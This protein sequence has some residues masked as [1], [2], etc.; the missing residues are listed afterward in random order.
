LLELESDPYSIFI[1]AMNAPQTREKYTTRLE[2]FFDFIDLP[3]SNNTTT[4]IEER[5]KYFVEKAKDDQKWLLNNV[6][7]FLLVQ[8]ERVER[9]RKLQEPQSE[10]MLKR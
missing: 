10:I 9:K 8:K 7:K 3:V 6:L 4:S 1:F 2:R 5:C